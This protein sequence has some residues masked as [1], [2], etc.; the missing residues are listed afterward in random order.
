R[1]RLSRRGLS[2]SVALC[3]SAL[4]ESISLA[5]LPPTSVLALGKAAS[6]LAAGQPLTQGIFPAHTLALA[7]EVLKAMFLTKLKTFAAVVLCIGVLTAQVGGSLIQ[8][9]TAQEAKKPSPETLA[10]RMESSDEEFIRRLS[11]DLRG[12]D[13]TPTEVY[14]FVAN[15]APGKR[16]QLIDLFI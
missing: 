11:R 10:A 8:I 15:R 13:P 2:V 9:G 7:Q 5:S 4:E 16:Q 14:F 6:K 1:E 12:S 3:A